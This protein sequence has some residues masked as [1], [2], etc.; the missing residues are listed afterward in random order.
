VHLEHL[1]LFDFERPAILSTKGFV[2]L[3]IALV[4]AVEIV[5]AGKTDRTITHGRTVVCYCDI[6]VLTS[7]NGTPVLVALNCFFGIHQHHFLMEVNRQ[8]ETSL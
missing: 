4:L 8:E 5:T 6:C 1:V 3:L 7:E 2:G